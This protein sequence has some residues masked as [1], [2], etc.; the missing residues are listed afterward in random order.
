ML[1]AS[2]QMKEIAG[3]IATIDQLERVQVE[4]A[5]RMLRKEGEQMGAPALAGKSVL[6]GKDVPD[7][8]FGRESE[9]MQFGLV[10]RVKQVEGGTATLFVWDGE[11]FTRVSTNVM[12]SDGTRAV[13][14]VLDPRGKAFAALSH[15]QP[16][17]G[18]VDIL[19]VPYITDY[20]PMND[21]HGNLVGA[22]YAGYRL[23]SIA[24]IGASVEKAKILDH[25][26]FA[27]LK[28]SGKIVFHGS[29]VTDAELEAI[30]AGKPGWKLLRTSDPVWGYT[31]LAAY[32]RT[33]IVKLEAELLAFP[34]IGTVSL[35]ITVIILQLVMLRRLI[36]DPLNHLT[37]TLAAADLNTLLD[38]SQDNEIGAL[39]ASFNQ[40][41]L[42]LRQTLFKVRDGSAEATGKSDQIR[43]ISEVTVQQMFKQ[44]QNAEDAARA[45][46]ALSQD[47]A[48]ISAHT[49]DASAQSRSAAQAARQG[50]KLVSSSVEL[51]QR[52]S[53]DTQ[54]S[55]DRIQKLTARAEEI[56]TIVSVIEGI[57]AGTNLLALNASIE[58]ARAGEHGRGF[59]VVAGEVR[60]L[61]ERTAEATQQVARLVSGVKNE[62]AGAASE[63]RTACDR[64]LE[65]A[66]T[67]SSLSS[68]F[69]HI[70][71]VTIE[72]DGQVEKIAVAA[73]QVA[74]AAEGVRNVMNELAASSQ[75]NSDG[76][77]EIVAASG[78]L[79]ETASSLESMV[80]TFDLRELPQDRAA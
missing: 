20:E 28:P 1:Q 61:A 30:A 31:V 40:Y 70:T 66:S 9:V 53:E 64:A 74:E 25:G 8:H 12:K 18:V 36:L 48:S 15:G 37:A 19:D 26:Q 76:A 79:L 34:A 78:K 27:L 77:V 23:D 52:L 46:E 13:G 65:S 32:P 6:G 10:D 29:Q 50:A 14:T 47:I 44:R 3:R 62:T 69:D 4:G 72:V 54:K 7:L 67:V 22:W 80:D 11:K 35:M 33:D 75:R 55:A 41:V 16:F 60:R 49:Q 43:G 57:A 63:I 73:R 5:M 56:G 45:I 38:A 68:T 51:M 17:E 21:S 39:A 24:S 42:G 71:G 58:A 59:A 2:V